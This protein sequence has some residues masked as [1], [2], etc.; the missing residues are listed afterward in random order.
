MLTLFDLDGFKAYNDAYGHPAGDAVLA[1][2]A[3]RLRHSLGA[4]ARAYRMGGD[5]FC[6][7][8]SVSHARAMELV[9]ASAAALTE[10][11]DGFAIGASRGTA[12]PPAD[13]R[14]RIRRC[15]WPT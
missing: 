13:R 14:T 10:E 12:L 7:L 15:A 4:D 3:Q 8:A 1:R 11:G 9:E 5:E 2:L 6:V